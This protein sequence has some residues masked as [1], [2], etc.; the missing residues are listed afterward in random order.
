MSEAYLEAVDYLYN[1]TPQFQSIGAAAYKPGLQTVGLLAEVFGNPHFAY[2]VIHVG[3]TNGK[4]S[5]SHTLASVL[6]AAGYRV[7]LYTSPH[8]VDFRERMRVNGQMIPEESVVS[9]VRNYRSSDASDLLSPSFF[10]LTTVMAFDWFKRMN[11]DIAVIEVGLGGRLDSTNIVDP[12]L[13]VITNISFDHMA[14]L[15]N[16]LEMIAAEKAGIMRSGVPVIIGEHD[17][18]IREFLGN[19][20]KEKGT[21]PVYAALKFPDINIKSSDRGFLELVNTPY[22]DLEFEL[23]GDCQHENVLTILAALMELQRLG[24]KIKADDVK[25]GLRNVCAATGLMGRWMT[26]ADMPLTICDTG[27][28]IGGWRWLGPQIRKLPRPLTIILGFVNDKDTSHIFSML[29]EDAEIIYTNADIP[30]A[31]PAGELGERG[32]AAG[33]PGKIIAGVGKAYREALIHNPAAVFIGGSTFV[34][35]DFLKEL[36]SAQK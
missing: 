15:G 28:N 8:L 13:S 5:T 21:V 18:D 22:G 6:Q 3:G 24:W 9:F 1:Q 7:G 27:H 34:V 30:R 20:A 17:P 26:V 11:V 29:P 14:Q 35:A 23:T 2:P 36:L 31:L 10:E 19:C 33:R 16:T 32:A 25:S 4:G 12:Q